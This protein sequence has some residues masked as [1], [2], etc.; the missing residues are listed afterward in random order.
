[1]SKT[2]KILKCSDE[3]NIAYWQ[4]PGKSPGVIFLTGF[5]SDMNGTK[6]IALEKFCH[7]RGQAFLRFDYTGHGQSSGNFNDGTIG[8]WT[9][10]A[11]LVLDK[12]CEGPQV[13]VGSSMGGWIMLLVAIARPQKIVGLVGT[14]AAPDFTEDLIK[15]KF[16]AEQ[17]DLLE[18]QGF[19]EI[20][21]CYNEEPYRITKDLLDEGRNHLLLT[22]K[23]PIDCPVRLIHGDEDQDVPWQTSLHLSKNI[24]S[25]NVEVLFVKGG[26]HRLSEPRD[27]DRL[28][29]ILNNLLSKL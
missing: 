25:Q 3:K 17:I 2:P 7:A 13:L 26:D 6:A 4:T 23:I 8:K 28:C 9:R 29:L 10:D 19:L 22:S 20:P 11:I 24:R 18:K 21:N 12:L 14:A 1:M 5:K 15:N 16:S 27:L